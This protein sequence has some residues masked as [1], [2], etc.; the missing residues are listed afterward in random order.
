MNLEFG[1]K[2]W[3]YNI[4]LAVA[5]FP[6]ILKRLLLKIQSLFSIKENKKL[7]YIFFVKRFFCC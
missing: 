2:L 4:A 3:I 6:S 7:L 1:V 5:S